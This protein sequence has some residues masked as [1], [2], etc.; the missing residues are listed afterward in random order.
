M[1]TFKKQLG[2]VGLGRMGSGMARRL[3]ASGFEVVGYTRNPAKTEVPSLER[4][5]EAL[6]TPRVVL[7]SLP[8]GDVTRSTIRHL[9]GL[10]DRGDF[11]VDTANSYYRD[12]LAL[13]DELAEAGIRFVDAGISGGVRGA[14]AGYCIMV[15]GK[16]EDVGEL[17][18]I[19]EALATER[20]FAHVGP[21]GAGHF[22]K[23]VHNGIEYGIIEALAEGYELLQA[24]SFQLDPRQIFELWQHGS[25][26]RSWLLELAT[27]ALRAHPGMQDVKG[28]VADSGE[29]RWTVIEATQMGV[30]VPVIATALYRRFD[31]R[32]ADSPAMQLSAALREQ[33]GGHEIK[34]QEPGL[35]KDGPHERMK[36]S[37]PD[38]GTAQ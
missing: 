19:F 13:A 4:L 15:G 36:E 34:S 14:E 10:L 20:G 23:M 12:T 29:G 9:A 3:R 25:V 5:V 18:P 24:S 7:T 28:W 32:Q 6:G 17:R 11:V 35:P 2:I 37:R 16:A 30:P 26:I 38:S 31:S 22:A 21:V 1:A 27:E 33:F 8:A